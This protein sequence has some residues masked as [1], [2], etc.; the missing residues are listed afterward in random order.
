M[1]PAQAGPAQQRT[2]QADEVRVENWLAERQFTDRRRSAFGGI[3]AHQTP[4]AIGKA[5][6]RRYFRVSPY[7]DDLGVIGLLRSRAPFRLTESAR[8]IAWYFGHLTPASAPDGV[9]YEHFYLRDGSGE[10]VT[11]VPGDPRLDRYNDATDSAAAT[12]LSLLRDYLRAGG[13]P[14][15][16]LSPGRRQ[17]LDALADT[18][19]RLQD[20]D[21]LFWAKTTYRVK[22]LEDNCE[23]YNG[24]TALA[25]LERSLYRNTRRAENAQHAASKLK[26]A[27][28]RDL[29]DPAGGW[30][31]AKL[32][33]GAALKAKTQRWFPDMQCQLWPVL[34]GIVSPASP[35]AA[36]TRSA[37]R[38]RWQGA[39]SA[40]TDWTRDVGRFNNGFINADVAFGALL[41][42]DRN[43]VAT[44]LES[45]RKLKFPDRPSSTDFEWPFTPLDAGWL[46]RIYARL[47]PRDQAN[48]DYPASGR[49]PVSAATLVSAPSCD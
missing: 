18:L 38:N 9:P 20:T 11:P 26:R 6:G 31:V 12:F 24:L 14:S 44:Y 33:N 16:L 17:K 48:R 21:G 1:P 36:A 47:R 39:T 25:E 3:C 42:G 5:N 34:Y 37:L 13:A 28:L 43:A 35:E 30:Y 22:Y 19:L 7:V 10:T 41:I 27:V 29:R 2:F 49:G 23:V 46:L 45:V 15:H 8:W 4:S 40:L 32:E